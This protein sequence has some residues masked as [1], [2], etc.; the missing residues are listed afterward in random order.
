MKGNIKD[1]VFSA[2]PEGNAKWLVVGWGK[3]INDASGSYKQQIVLRK[4]SKNEDPG[5]LKRQDLGNL[6]FYSVVDIGSIRIFSPGTIVQNQKIKFFIEDYLEKRTFRIL[7]PQS[8]RK[9]KLHHY[10]RQSSL[11]L[12]SDLELIKVRSFADS[13]TNLLVVVPCSVI[14]DYYY[15]G[16]TPLTKAIFEGTFDLE[17]RV[18]NTVFNPH[19]VFRSVSSTKKNIGYI[20]LDRRMVL[21]DRV[22][23]GRLALDGFFWNKCMGIFTS[24]IEQESCG[25]FMET[26]F[27]INEP[28]DLIVYGVT[29]EKV[30]LVHSIS[31][32]TA[33][34]PFDVLIAGKPFKGKEQRKYN[35]ESSSNEVKDSLFL[36][37]SQKKNKKKSR[38]HLDSS[39]ITL[40]KMDRP[41][42]D[43]GSESLSY[44]KDQSNSFLEEDVINEKDLIDPRKQE[45]IADFI[46]KNGLAFALS[47]NPDKLGSEETLQLNLFARGPFTPLKH[48]PTNAFSIFE[49]LAGALEAALRSQGY[50]VQSKICCPEK[51][52]NDPYTAFPIS[53]IRSDQE[54]NKI[55]N[56]NF[57]FL[58]VK[59]YAHTIYRRVFISHLS[60]DGSNLYLVD[61][62][63]KYSNKK[64]EKFL[65]SFGVI[66]HTGDFEL[67]EMELKDILIQI[68]VSHKTADSRWRFL[69][70]KFGYSYL[71]IKHRGL[72]LSYHNI[73]KFLFTLAF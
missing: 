50:N 10:S 41:K 30:F 2:L 28:T 3:T 23:I 60:I 71:K 16:S 62:E 34:P 64:T 4:L 21:D 7:D 1:L 33:K 29:I 11:P 19:R 63:P 39:T 25:S 35:H 47:T 68:V 15:F 52:G 72:N 32:C 54:L 61:I 44:D 56:V 6:L 42:W 14:A 24:M 40:V 58:Q 66:F 49:K 70:R 31:K 67:T 22:K 55:E 59:K 73:L 18:R 9:S 17:K 13:E 69:E 51:I 5:H 46:H 20:E 26:D 65:A 12:F 36:T 48:L 27:P 38:T 37:G 53:M 57:C 8:L 45:Q 43:A